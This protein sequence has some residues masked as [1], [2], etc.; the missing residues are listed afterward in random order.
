IAKD[1]RSE[2]L[3]ADALNFAS[4]I[5]ASIFA[6]LGLLAV[7]FGFWQGDSIGALGVAVFIGIAGFNLARRTINA[8]TD[9][10]PPGLTES[11]NAAALRV[12]GVIGV[13]SLRL[14]PVGASVLGDIA[15]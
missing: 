10:A 6:L 8:L 12:P 15:I 11:I 1:T 13:D 5:V 14:R 2:P 3:A 7:H 9:A 4:D